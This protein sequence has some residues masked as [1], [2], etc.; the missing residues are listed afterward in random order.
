MINEFPP[1]LRID[2]S[3]GAEFADCLRSAT[4]AEGPEAYSLTALTQICVDHHHPAA[5]CRCVVGLLSSR[6][7]RGSPADKDNTFILQPAI[8]DIDL[9]RGGKS[10]VIPGRGGGLSSELQP[11]GRR[12]G[13][14]LHRGLR[15]RAAQPSHREV[16]FLNGR[17]SDIFRP[18]SPALPAD[19]GSAA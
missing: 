16:T 3:R 7:S 14:A 11:I 13:T 2:A 8:S 12:S 10:M 19:L 1:T 9:S 5:F 17:N 6:G 15:A 18:E 4:A